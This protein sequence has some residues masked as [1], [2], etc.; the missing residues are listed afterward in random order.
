M[1]VHSTVLSG[2]RAF[3]PTPIRDERGFFSRPFDAAIFRDAGIDPNAFFH[4]SMSRNV[5]VDLPSYRIDREHDPAEDVVIAQLT[6]AR[7]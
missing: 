3:R 6:G 4:D 7:P 2:V 5:V 1:H